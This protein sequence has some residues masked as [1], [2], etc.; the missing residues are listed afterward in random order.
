MTLSET[1]TTV[2]R[3][4]AAGRSYDQILQQHPELTYFDVFAA[5]L[6]SSLDTLDHTAATTPSSSA[7]ASSPAG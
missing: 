7:P 3:L 1:A 6:R 4:I 5:A 2:L